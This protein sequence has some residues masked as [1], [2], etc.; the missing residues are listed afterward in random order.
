G[1]P[2]WILKTLVSLIFSF[3]SAFAVPLV[4][5]ISK[6]SFTNSRATVITASLSASLTLTKTFPFFGSGGG[7]ALFGFA[8]GGP[9]STSTPITSPVDFI[10]GPS[11]ISKPSYRRNGNTASFTEKCFGTI[12]FMK[13]SSR[14]DFPVITLAASFASGTPI[15]LLTNGTVRDAR[16]FT[17]STSQYL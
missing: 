14:N 5:M 4:E 10:S 8:E 15:A 13:P 2:S 17:S 16:G 12:S 6:P 11:E 1:R 3:V 7:A 9:R